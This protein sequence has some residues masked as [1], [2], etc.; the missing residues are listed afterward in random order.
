MKIVTQLGFTGQPQDGFEVEAQLY[1]ASGKAM[2]KQPLRGAV[3]AKI[4]PHN[5]YATPP[6]NHAVFETEIKNPKIWS[7]ETPHLY[8]VVVSLHKDDE[9]IEAT[10]CRVGFRRV[11][12]GNRELLVNGKPVMMRGMNRH[13]HDGVTGKAITRESMIR[14]IE[15]MKQFNVNAVRTSHYPNDEKWYDLCDEYGLY[16]I[17]EANLESHDFMANLCRDGRYAPAFVDRALRMV[18]RDKNHPSVIIWSLGNESGYGPNHDAMAGW[19]RGYDSSR[20]LHYEGAVWGWDKGEAAGARVSD[21]ICPMYSSIESIVKWAQ[22]DNANDR[23]PLILCEYSHAMGNSN[24]SLG[25]YWDAF[26][27]YHGLQGGFIW[28]WVDH[29]ILQRASDGREYYAYGGD[30]GDEPNDLNFCCDGIVATDRTPHPALY[31]FKKLSQPI[32]VRW[33]SEKKNLLEITNK[34]DFTNLSDVRGE[35]TLEVDGKAIKSGKLPLLKTAPGQSE[36]VEIK[37]PSPEIARGQEAFLMVRFSLAKDA[38]WASAGHEIAWEQLPIKLPVAKTTRV[39]PQRFAPLQMHEENGQIIVSGENLEV[40]FSRENGVLANYKVSGEE[41]ILSGPKLQ[42]WRGA[43]D[44][45]GIKGWSGQDGKPLG[46]WLNAG[47]HEIVFNTPEISSTANRN[48]S[49]TVSIR[50]SVNCKAGE[51]VLVHQHVYTIRPDGSVRVE[52]LFRVDAALPDLPRLGVTMTLPP[53]FENLEWFGHGPHENYSDRNR[54]SWISRFQSTVTDEYV[55]YV[56]PQEHGNKT[57]LR[58]M[59]LKSETA[60]LRFALDKPGEGSAS[61]FTPEDLFAAKHTTDLTPRAETIVNLDV[62]QRGLGT[63]SCGPDTL[64]QYRI[65]PGDYQLDFVIMPLST[66]DSTAL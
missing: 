38:S 23:R 33:K 22:E 37:V 17:D 61:H 12:M 32:A 8:T 13:E 47:L 65:E 46:R 19:I 44:N 21:I 34:R 25:D 54:A 39:A 15:L 60:G 64:P 53:Q 30:F 43:T 62:A 40:V 14:D 28:E 20:P 49:V 16:L 48:G 6:L 56:L 18:E 58:W 2:L 1:D 26:E 7:S 52:N 4:Y 66:A 29:G 5:P 3:I 41:L 59:A 31:E 24:G 27:K 50:Q 55:D 63:A 9:T 35:W 11:E 51:N 10:P 57:E 42:V 36:T 45:D